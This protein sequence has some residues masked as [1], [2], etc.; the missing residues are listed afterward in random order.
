MKPAVVLAAM[1]GNL[2]A[3]EIMVELGADIEVPASNVRIV[4]R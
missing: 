1:H 2:K 3:L 4:L